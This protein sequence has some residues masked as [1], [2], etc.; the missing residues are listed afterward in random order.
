[1]SGARGSGSGGF[2]AATQEG[3]DGKQPKQ[4]HHGNGDGQ[5]SSLGTDG[6]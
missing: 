6:R 5:A 4:D 1:M 2:L 3:E